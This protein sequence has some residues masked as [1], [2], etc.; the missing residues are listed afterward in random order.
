MSEDMP[1]SLEYQEA[2]AEFD[3]TLDD[4]GAAVAA[5]SSERVR[6]ILD[7]YKRATHKLLAAHR[8]QVIDDLNGKVLDQ[9]LF[10]D[11]LRNVEA[12][13]DVRQVGK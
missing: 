8:R 9:G 5:V 6:G 3:T 10:E 11:R 13:L 7:R 12:L 1:K 2:I 4:V